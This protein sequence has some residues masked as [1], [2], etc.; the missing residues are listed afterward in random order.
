MEFSYLTKYKMSVFKKKKTNTHFKR[1]RRKKL[2]PS[3]GHILSAQVAITADRN[4]DTPD[5]L[6]TNFT[7]LTHHICQDDFSHFKHFHCCSFLTNH[8]LSS[9]IKELSDQQSP[10]TASPGK[11]NEWEEQSSS[12][13]WQPEQ[14]RAG[15]HLTQPQTAHCAQPHVSCVYATK[16]H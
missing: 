7:W 5:P 16:T 11:Q 8:F 10:V 4:C 13:L 6:A 9:H 1:R 12:S 2:N 14:D 3:H 15:S